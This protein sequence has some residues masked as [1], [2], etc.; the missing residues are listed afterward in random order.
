MPY[1][2]SWAFNVGSR[3]ARGRVLV[4]HDNDML[5]PTDY[6]ALVLGRVLEGFEVVNLK[7]FL[8]Y[9]GAE[10]SIALLQLQQ[11]LA[12]SRPES[13]VQ[14]TE[15]GGSI[16]I[17][18]D[19]YSDI[20]GM[21]ESFIGWGGEDNEFWERAQ[22]LRVWNYG[23]LPMIH[24]WHAAQ[25][26]KAEVDNPTLSRHRSLAGIPLAQRITKLRQTPSGLLSGPSGWRNG[27]D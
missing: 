22:S 3:L 21:D 8:F 9:L 4:L 2:R 16:A 5:I 24:L 7:R 13:I 20:G 27:N 12:L 25:P 6:A 10:D 1:C 26:R 14:N 19:S 18:R 17:M 15:G 23:S 11:E